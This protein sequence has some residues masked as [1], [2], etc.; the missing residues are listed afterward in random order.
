MS[1]GLSPGSLK[2]L[3]K[4]KVEDLSRSCPAV[5]ARRRHPLDNAPQPRSNGIESP[6]EDTGKRLE[7][8]TAMGQLE[9][10]LYARDTEYLCVG[11][12]TQ[13]RADLPRS[14]RRRLGQLVTNERHEVSGSLLW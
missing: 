14:V 5:T 7:I 12:A 3:G 8:T 1:T 10:V 9:S 13:I 11:Y 6:G 2:N 4:R